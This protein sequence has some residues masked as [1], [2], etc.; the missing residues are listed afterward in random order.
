RLAIKS[1]KDIDFSGDVFE[2]VAEIDA[3][4]KKAMEVKSSSDWLNSGEITQQLI[5]NLSTPKGE[6][7]GLTTGSKVIDSMN[8][9]LKPGN[10]IIIA[11]RPGMGKSAYMG[12]MAM[13]IVRSGKKVGVISLEMPAVDVFARM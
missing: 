4:V 5:K 2:I 6:M 7:S 1:T 11:A 8:G 12:K 10:M 3:K 9:G 13:D